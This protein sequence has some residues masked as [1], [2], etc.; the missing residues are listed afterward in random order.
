VE[1]SRLVVLNARDAEA[2]GARILTR[3]RVL[4]AA[5]DGDLWRVTVERDGERR[6][7]TA[8]ALVN[9]GGPWVGDIIRTSPGRT[10]PRRSASC[11]AAIS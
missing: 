11:A 1:D 10:R 4:S 5:R 8:R 2:R 9:A 3:A 6:E 7:I